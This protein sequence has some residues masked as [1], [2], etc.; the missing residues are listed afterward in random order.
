[1]HFPPSA[2]SR[3][4]VFSYKQKS[5]VICILLLPL[6]QKGLFSVTTECL[7]TEYWLT[8]SSRLALAKS[9]VRLTNHLYKTI[10]VVWDVKP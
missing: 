10:A 1:M 6:I 8:A 7:C 2:D 9:V 4:A 3:R 5:M